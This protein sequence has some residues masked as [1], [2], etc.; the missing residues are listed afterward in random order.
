MN[1]LFASLSVLMALPANFINSFMRYFFGTLLGLNM[2]A[3]LVG[4]LW[5]IFAYGNWGTPFYAFLVSMFS[6][7]LLA[8]PLMIAMLFI[9][10]AVYLFERGFLGK[11]ISVPFMILSNLVSWI[12]YSLWTIWAFYY[13]ITLAQ[14]DDLMP[15]LLIAY[16]LSTSPWM[17]MASKE[18]PENKGTLFPLFF[19]QASAAVNIF[20]IGF[21][22]STFEGIVLPF[23]TIMCFGFLLTLFAGAVQL[24]PNTKNSQN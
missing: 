4:G 9:V 21:Y 22:N 1:T 19:T 10:P 8:F 23:V 6:P 13:C 17:F 14:P 3:G 11:L 15:H 20:T 24:I 18:P 16:S 7:F 5:L 12:V 2:L